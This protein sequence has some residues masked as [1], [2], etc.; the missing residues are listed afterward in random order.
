[1]IPDRRLENTRPIG[2]QGLPAPPARGS[3]S[4]HSG[5]PI[6]PRGLELIITQIP[7]WAKVDFQVA[8]GSAFS[9]VADRP[10]RQNRGVSH[11]RSGGP[12]KERSALRA[13]FILMGHPRLMERALLLRDGRVPRSVGIQS[14]QRTRS[15]LVLVGTVARDMRPTTSACRVVFVFSKTRRKCVFTVAS[16]TPRTLAT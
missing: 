11:R 5:A 6:G 2:L 13:V 8:V 4:L 12:T 7:G 14:T 16:P 3:N 9:V 15:L 10:P 1:M